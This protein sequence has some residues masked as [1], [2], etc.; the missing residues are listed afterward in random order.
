MTT[1]TT[2]GFFSRD[3]IGYVEGVNLFAALFAIQSM[4]PSG[5]FQA[6]PDGGTKQCNVVSTTVKQ[7]LGK[8]GG[9]PFSIP[10]L[11]IPTPFGPLTIKGKEAFK[12]TIFRKECLKD[13]GCGVTSTFVEIERSIKIL[14]I[15]GSGINTFLTT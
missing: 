11:P 14:N 1:S 12:F 8:L 2:I 15:Y 10:S 6:R 9:L 3:P 4:D 7:D 13:C 5:L